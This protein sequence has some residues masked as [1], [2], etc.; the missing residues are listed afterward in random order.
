[1]RSTCAACSWV[2]KRSACAYA[3]HAVDGLLESLKRGAQARE[4]PGRRRVGAFTPQV[5]ESRGALGPVH[6][7]I[8]PLVP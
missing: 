3:F 2:C 4:Q 5:V 8:S 6:C 1:V 7:R